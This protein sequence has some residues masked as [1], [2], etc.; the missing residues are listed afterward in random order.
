MMV[1][2]AGG[3]KSGL[4]TN[5]GCEFKAQQVPIESQCTVKVRYF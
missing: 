2:S 3:K 1:I 4:V 5:H